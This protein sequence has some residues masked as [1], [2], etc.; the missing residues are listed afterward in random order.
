MGNQ[1]NTKNVIKN[2]CCTSIKVVTTINF[3]IDLNRVSIH[4][5]SK[6]GTV[7]QISNFEMTTFFFVALTLR[8]GKFQIST[9][10]SPLEN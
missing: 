5:K 2:Q 1:Q 6:S 4:C 8:K 9:T 3:P 10:L 7:I